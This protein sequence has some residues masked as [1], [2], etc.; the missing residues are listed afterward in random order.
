MA[1]V[2]VAP[3]PY[4]TYYGWDEETTI[5]FCL[6]QLDTL[7]HGQTTP[8]ETAAEL[9]ALVEDNFDI[10]LE[11]IGLTHEDLDNPQRQPES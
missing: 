5:E 1:G 4:A 8:E 9:Q 11:N 6:K 10:I 7:L 2:S 3:Y